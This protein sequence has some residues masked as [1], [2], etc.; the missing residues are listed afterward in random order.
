MPSFP[1]TGSMVDYLEKGEVFDVRRTPSRVGA[2][3]EVFRTWP[4]VL[5]SLHPTNPVCAWGRDAGRLLQGHE[6]SLT[7]YGSETPY[8]RL[9]GREDTF[10]LMIETHIHSFI[11][12]IQERVELPTLFL[13]EERV[14]TCVDYQGR[15]QPIRTRVMRPRIPYFLAVPSP[16]GSGPEWALAHDFHLVFPRRRELELRRR[17]HHFTGYPRLLQRRRQ[18]EEAG[19]LR[20]ARLGLGE[21]GLLHI[22]S[23]LHHIEPEL[24]ELI[25]RFRT[26][27][28]AERIQQLDLEYF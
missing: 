5:R 16:N 4:Q 26:Y 18:L 24:R 1:M 8:G 12:H 17:G 15:T 3:T 2:I 23:Y 19:I 20:T 13:P 22:H 14:G 11:H 10:I 9:A 21:V 6:K 7:P 28:D 25:D 27:Y